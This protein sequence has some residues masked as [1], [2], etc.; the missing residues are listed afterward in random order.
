M[1]ELWQD[2]CRRAGIELD[3][4]RDQQLR[5][6]LDLL[7]TANQRTNLTRITDRAAAE[8]LHVGDALTLLPHL[9]KA[10]HRLA[11]VGS[12]GGVPGIVL[13]IVR[14]ESH[15]TLIESTHKKADFLRGAAAELGLKNLDVQA[16][17]AEDAGR[18]AMRESFDVAAARAVATLDWLAEWLLPL[19]AK[20]G[21]VLAMKG[22]RVRQELPSAK[23]VF[24]AL[25]GGE[26]EVLPAELPGNENHVVVRVPK[27]AATDPRY[28]RN[29]TIARGR[30]LNL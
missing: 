21:V 17:R 5:R 3:D 19:V 6:Y 13:A 27:V 24:R 4:S 29:A 22:P 10:P 16:V 11:D 1:N 14:P 8:V 30:A 2:L 12:G 9:P 15:V 7:L 20:G 26:A 18:G 25:G 23:P 28:P